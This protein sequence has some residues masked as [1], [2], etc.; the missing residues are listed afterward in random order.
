MHLAKYAARVTMLIRGES[1]AASMSSYLVSEIEHAPNIST[2]LG[3]EV[4]DGAGA[5]RLQTIAVRRRNSSVVD[6]VPASALFLLIGAEPLTGSAA[7]LCGAEREG[8]RPYRP[9]FAQP[10]C[11]GASLAFAA[12]SDA[13]GNE[14]A[15]RVRRRGRTPS[16]HQARRGRRRRRVDRHSA[17]P[18]LSQ[19]LRR[20]KPTV[21]QP[22][23]AMLTR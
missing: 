6:V 7:R 16:I 3:A 2:R 21:T 17:H 5:G 9:T 12:P 4:V 14:H 10:G 13:V 19:R 22:T 20:V 1:L 23:F 11:P 8:L 18:R 15:G